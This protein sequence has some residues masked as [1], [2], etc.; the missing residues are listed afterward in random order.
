MP[1]IDWSQVDALLIVGLLAYL[2]KQQTTVNQLKQAMLG[3]GKGQGVI[4]EVNALRTELNELRIS[5]GA[6]TAEIRV[7]NERRSVPRE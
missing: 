3:F 6:L 1:P 2:W 5:V 4:A 7:S